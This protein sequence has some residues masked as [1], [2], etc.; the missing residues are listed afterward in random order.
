MEKETKTAPKKETTTKKKVAGKKAT[1][2][3]NKKTNQVMKT[4]K[5]PKKESMSKTSNAKKATETLEK[6]E[7]IQK[8]EKTQEIELTKEENKSL[9]STKKENTYQ[10]KGYE[11]VLIAACLALLVTL[12]LMV[13]KNNTKA[14]CQ[15]A[16]CNEDSTICYTYKVDENGNTKKTWVGSCAKK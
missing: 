15:K 10:M 2:A 16:I 3:S 1:T 14:H 7:K 13:N 12:I 11:M 8:E 9:S 5:L 4:N 6:T